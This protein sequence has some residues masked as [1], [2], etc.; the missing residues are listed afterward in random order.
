MSVKI[1]TNVTDATNALKKLKQGIM[2]AIPG[3]I[4]NSTRQIRDTIYNDYRRFGNA[5]PSYL[6]PSRSGAG[7]TDRSGRL[8][9]S[10]N[11]DI[12]IS[13]T[14]VVGS[15]EA[16]MDYAAY[17]ELLWSGKYAYLVPALTQNYGYIEQQVE[18]A[19]IKAVMRL[20]K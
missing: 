6:N 16:G 1:T 20:A 12:Q 7:F 18:E 15:V 3:A 5:A 11:Q 8:R 13:S 9:A 19:V 2:W 17:V 14:K 4:N 10:I